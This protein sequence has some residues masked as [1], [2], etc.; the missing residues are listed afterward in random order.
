[1]K[2]LHVFASAIVLAA[3]LFSAVHA[4]EDVPEVLFQSYKACKP[5]PLP[6]AAIPNLSVA[7]AYEIQKQFVAKLI[8]D[9][10]I[11]AGYKAGLTS[12]PA[13][14]KFKAPGPVTGI[15]LKNM[16]ISDGKVLSKPFTKMMLEVE[17]GYRL[18]QDIKAP[19]T[20]ETVNTLVD[21]IMPAVEVPDLNFAT[22]KGL[23]FT[24]IIADNVGARAFILGNPQTIDKV[25]PN[26]VTGQLFM[27]EKAL[28]PAVP[29]RAALGDQWKALSW[30]LNNVLA[31]GGEIKRG[32][33][34]ITGSLG[35]MYPGKS[36]NY[37]AVYTG[38]LDNLS[39]T[40]K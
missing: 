35:R 31:N 36:G 24:D 6:S 25:D 22:F 14:K 40:I 18:N 39:F 9:G 7:Q 37:K 21:A 10:A 32:M 13:Q 2:K 20:P 23:A 30:S 11:V 16:Q 4:G 1:M 28:G 27:N 15:L 8:T 29:G 19:T 3:F 34:V 33:V 5:V 17:I 12:A 38:G 26:G